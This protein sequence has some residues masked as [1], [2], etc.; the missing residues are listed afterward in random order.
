MNEESAISARPRSAVPV[1]RSLLW[2]GRERTRIPAREAFKH[3]E[4][5]WRHVKDAPMSA[6]EKKL[7]GRLAK[8]YGRGLING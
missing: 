3:Y 6:V 7:L 8:D 4:N 2:T 5:N 1:L